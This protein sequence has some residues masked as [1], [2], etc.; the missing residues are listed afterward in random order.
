MRRAQGLLLVGL[1]LIGGGAALGE[2]DEVLREIERDIGSIDTKVRSDALARLI[3]VRIDVERSV[4]L[5]RRASRDPE[6]GIRET[7]LRGLGTRAFQRHP[8]AI[9]AFADALD[10][11]EPTIARMAR[12]RILNLEE[13]DV[14]H[15]PVDRIVGHLVSAPTEEDRFHF[16][17]I[18][19]TLL[20]G[21]ASFPPGPLLACAADAANARLKACALQTAL[22]AAAVSP[23]V[24]S[25]LPAIRRLRGSRAGDVRFD[26]LQI[27]AKSPGGTAIQVLVEAEAVETEKVIVEFLLRALVSRVDSPDYR[28]ALE[29]LAK[30]TTD[31]RVRRAAE[32]R[33]A[34]D[35]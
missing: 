12:E 14:H 4:P 29:E 30:T 15:L 11:S 33:L 8:E 18:A 25:D 3:S 26:V 32:S 35:R 20:D 6:R 23:I 21:K 22:K 28:P 1:L 2:G 5:I 16:V 13:A 9:A 10:D 7:A 19:E 31:E 27:A 34:K 17:Q 24:S